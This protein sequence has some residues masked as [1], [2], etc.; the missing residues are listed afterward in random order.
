MRIILMRNRNEND[1]YLK[2]NPADCARGATAT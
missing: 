1:S 2:V